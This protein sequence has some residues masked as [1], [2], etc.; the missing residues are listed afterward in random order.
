MPDKKGM[1]MIT[2]SVPCVRFVPK[3]AAHEAYVDIISDADD[4]ED[5]CFATLGNMGGRHICHLA[6][7]GCLVS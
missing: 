4:G 7:T 1:N 6:R 3:T 5:G 2:D